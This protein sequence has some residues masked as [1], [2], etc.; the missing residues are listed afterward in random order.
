VISVDDVRAAAARLDGVAHRTPALTSRTLD[1]LVGAQVFLK[2]ENLQR[3][4]SF[5]LR[6]ALNKIASLPPSVTAV[7][8]GSAG[9]HAQAVAY[10]GKRL[11]IPVTIVM[12]ERLMPANSAPV[13]AAPITPASL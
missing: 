11:G 10:H 7:V 3:G 1:A 4:G 9:N 8:C 12:P 5:K 13:C 2:A 6:G